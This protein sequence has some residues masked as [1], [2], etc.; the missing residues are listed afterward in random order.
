MCRSHRLYTHINTP[1]IHRRGSRNSDL[2]KAQHDIIQTGNDAM[3]F[4]VVML[5]RVTILPLCL[6][7][8]STTNCTSALGWKSFDCFIFFLVQQLL[9]QRQSQA[10][11]TFSIR[12]HFRSAL[13]VQRFFLSAKDEISFS[14]FHL[15]EIPA[16][17]FYWNI[18]KTNCKLHLKFSFCYKRLNFFVSALRTYQVFP[19]MSFSSSLRMK[20]P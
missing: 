18:Y 9:N 7:M 6:I 11:L 8:W 14:F 4:E 16:L 13:T 12:T 2:E 1:T 5:L 10:C 17:W 20:A 3:G 15:Y 19:R